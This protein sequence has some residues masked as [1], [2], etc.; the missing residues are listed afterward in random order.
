MATNIID[1]TSMYGK[2]AYE[3]MTD[4]KIE[5]SDPSFSS[6]CLSCDVHLRSYEVQLL[7]PMA[8]TAAL[9]ASCSKLQA[10]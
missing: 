8:V 9:I 5:G 4:S 10:K 3:V 6:V 7:K 1:S 2:V